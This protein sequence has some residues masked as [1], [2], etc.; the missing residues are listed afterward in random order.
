MPMS[1]G[2][3]TSAEAKGQSTATVRRGPGGGAGVGAAPDA[4]TELQAFF[5]GLL[6][7]QCALVGGVAGI[8][9][10]AGSDARQAG[11][12]ATFAAGA[13]NGGGAGSAAAG[14][15]ALPPTALVALDRGLVARLERVG[16]T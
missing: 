11:V 6:Q 16:I 1:E 10:L 13:G 7:Q 8:V 12:A 5:V 3:I 2:S 9:Y 4:A 15:Q 14:D